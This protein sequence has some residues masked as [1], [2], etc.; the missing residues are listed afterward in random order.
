LGT[1]VY[2]RV[3]IYNPVVNLIIIGIYF[4]VFLILGSYLSARQE[5]NK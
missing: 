5:R 3:V 1:D 4:W 2:E